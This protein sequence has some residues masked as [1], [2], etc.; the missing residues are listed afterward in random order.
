MVEGEKYYQFEPRINDFGDN[1]HKSDEDVYAS[2][3]DAVRNLRR[4][5]RTYN[6]YAQA[7]QV[8]EKYLDNL[9]VKYGGPKNFK[10]AR[11]LGTVVEFVPPIPK[12]RKTEEN[13]LL[14]KYGILLSDKVFEVDYELSDEENE[15]MY[16]MDDWGPGLEVKPIKK[17]PMSLDKKEMRKLSHEENIAEEINLLTKIS[18]SSV[19]AG[20]KINRKSHKNLSKALRKRRKD[21]LSCQY[22]ERIEDLINT[23][24][25]DIIGKT[26]INDKNDE[27]T[28]YRGVLIPTQEM[29]AIHVSKSLHEAGIIDKDDYSAVRTKKLRKMMKKEEKK[30]KKGKKKKKNKNCI[31]NFVNDYT[32]SEFTSFDDVGREMQSLTADKIRCLED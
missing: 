2:I 27:T 17:N 16:N 32:D 18:E 11:Q 29:E 1:Y 4:K 6:E 13:R 7:L 20:G 30:K 24:N 22:T 15:K 10:I 19:L 25:N 26:Y 5:Y 9:M 8:I 12:F 21:L 31:D 3:D 28:L 14:D 23:Y